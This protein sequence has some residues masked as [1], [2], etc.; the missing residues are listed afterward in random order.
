MKYKTEVQR[1]TDAFKRD[2]RKFYDFA[3]R[4]CRNESYLADDIIQDSGEKVLLYLLRGGE[5]EDPT[6][7]FY[8]T[9]SLRAKTVM[10]QRKVRGREGDIAAVQYSDALPDFQAEDSYNPDKFS[11]ADFLG[12]IVV[13]K[14]SHKDAGID[15]RKTQ[16]LR[17]IFRMEIE[18]YTREEIAD[19]MDTTPQN[20]TERINRYRRKLKA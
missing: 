10:T 15:L 18:G 1:F 8:K 19:V 14:S 17:T 4:Y 20:I 6:R 13:R 2:Y 7:F 12:A 11:K 5:I 16:E 3:C 9:I